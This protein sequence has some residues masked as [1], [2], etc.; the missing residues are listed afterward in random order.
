MYV[1]SYEC[2]CT[3]VFCHRFVRVEGLHPLAKDRA[4]NKSESLSKLSIIKP[5]LQMILNISHHYKA[6]DPYKTMYLYCTALY[7]VV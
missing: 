2:V 4:G 5:R 7:T 1:C 3:N 6:T